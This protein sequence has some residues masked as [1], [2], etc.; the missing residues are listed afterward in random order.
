MV[1]FEPKEEK[2]LKNGA[3]MVMGVGSCGHKVSKI[4]S[5]KK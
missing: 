5:G 2:T 3:K 4:V 1:D